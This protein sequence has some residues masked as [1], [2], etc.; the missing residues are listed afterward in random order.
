M[1][2]ELDNTSLLDPDDDVVRVDGEDEVDGQTQ[3]QEHRHSLEK[4]SIHVS[5]RWPSPNQLPS[6]LKCIQD[7][8]L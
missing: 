3:V 6:S 5:T 8:P 7:W 1:V 4:H 2:Q